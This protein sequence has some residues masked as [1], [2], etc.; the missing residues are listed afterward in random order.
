M[1]MSKQRVFLT[2]A[3]GAMGYLGMLSL[4][5]DANEQELVVLVRPSAKNKELLSPYQ[6]YKDL[7]IRWGDLTNYD[8]VYACVD[9][10]D[11]VLH[12]AAFVSPAADYYPLEAMR[13]NYGAAKNLM[14]AIE[15]QG[16]K[17]DIRFVN[18]G[19]VAE[20][21]DRMIAV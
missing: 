19:T 21:G 16:R 8:D 15:A 17:E 1:S 7:T 4:L 18:I 6:G 9:G 10:A 13:I 3:T 20:T 2:G 14:Q 11:V 5:E 12:V